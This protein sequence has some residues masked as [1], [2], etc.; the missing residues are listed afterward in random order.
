MHWLLYSS[1]FN[2]N[3]QANEILWKG[4]VTLV[5]WS[6]LGNRRSATS[7]CQMP[8]R[9]LPFQ[10]VRFVA[11]L[12]EGHT[13]P[14]LAMLKLHRSK[15]PFGSPTF[16]MGPGHPLVF[17]KATWWLR[18]LRRVGSPRCVAQSRIFV[19]VANVSGYPKR[20]RLE[21]QILYSCFYSRDI[22]IL[23]EQVD[24]DYSPS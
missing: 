5:L 12:A 9:L 8:R 1:Q 24:W 11:Q 14:P 7:S 15:P 20:F 6:D 19:Y 16:R 2:C 10:K 18:T 4:F 22:Y 13:R 17:H 21:K 23:C 3:P